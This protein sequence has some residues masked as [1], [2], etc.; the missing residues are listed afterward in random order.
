MNMQL[1]DISTAYERLLPLEGGNNFRDFGGYQTA[2]QRQVRRGLLFRSGVMTSLTAEDQVFLDNLGMKTIVDFRSRE[3]LSLFPN[4]WATT[5]PVNLVMHD[6]SVN[7]IYRRMYDE[8]GRKFP[9]EHLYQIF[10]SM[11]VPQ[12]KLF[13]RHLVEGQS[14]AVV[15][16]SAGQDRTGIATALV[17][18]TLGVPWDTIIEDYHL[19]TRYRRPEIEHHG[20]DLNDHAENNAFAQMMLRYSDGDRTPK[21]L[22]TEDGT[23]YLKFAFEVIESDFGSLANYLKEALDVDEQGVAELQRLYLQDV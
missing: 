21:P 13:F 19:S 2:D 16:C 10:P 11:L 12:L 7:E 17:L 14:P 6:Y 22:K 1:T 8:S 20:V 9:I 18:A 4:H 23:P 5:S 15:N 3:E